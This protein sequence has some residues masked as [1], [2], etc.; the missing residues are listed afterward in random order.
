MDRTMTQ[1]VV[2]PDC[3]QVYEVVQGGVYVVELVEVDGEPSPQRLYQGSTLHCPV[4]GR[5]DVGALDLLSGV[6][7]D[8]LGLEAALWA[9]LV[10]D[11]TWVYYVLPKGRDV[12]WGERFGYTVKRGKYFNRA[13][14]RVQALLDRLLPE[15]PPDAPPA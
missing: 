6:S 4:C 8:P 7:L 1:L 3:E 11:Q 9:L 2:C 15:L 12:R 10:S 14:K 13:D 5:V